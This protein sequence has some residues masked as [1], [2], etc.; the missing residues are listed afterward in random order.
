MFF[1]QLYS[2][3]HVTGN[4]SICHTLS[5]KNENL[6]KHLGK[7]LLLKHLRL[8]VLAIKSQMMFQK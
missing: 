7:E 6:N 4:Q 1:F 3:C 8:W 5:R 2:V